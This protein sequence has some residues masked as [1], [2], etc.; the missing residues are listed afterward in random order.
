MELEHLIN[1]ARI[2]TFNLLIY[3]KNQV[4]K[5]FHKLYKHQLTFTTSFNRYP[6]LF[7]EIGRAME[8]YKKKEVKILS[9]GFVKKFNVHH[10]AI[11][12]PHRNCIYRKK[13][14]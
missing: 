7:E 2:R 9:S 14:E 12:E 10:N 5:F 4:N 1:K 6:E 13:Y 3:W 8:F 11:T